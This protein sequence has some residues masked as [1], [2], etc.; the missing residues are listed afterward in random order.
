MSGP[1]RSLLH[2]IRTA[3]RPPVHPRVPMIG[4]VAAVVIPILLH[5]LRAAWGDWV[6]TGDDAYFT[7][8][9][10]DVAT[11]H[12]PLLGAWSSG[13]VDLAEPINNLGPTQ[14]DL[15]APFTKPWPMGGTAVAVAITNAAAVIAIAVMV[16]RLAGRRAVIAAMVPVAL[17]AW[18][19]G[20]EMLITPRQH[21]YLILPYLCVLVATWAIAVGDRWAVPIGVVAASLTTQ[22]HLSYPVLVAVLGV[23]ALVGHVDAMRRGSTLGGRR[24]LVVASLLVLALWAQ[25][26]VDQFAGWGNLGAVLFGSG[27]TDRPG[28]VAGARM[29]AGLLVGP[30]TLFRPGYQRDDT[31]VLL[32]EVWQL[33]VF[34]VAVAAACAGAVVLFR[35]RRRRAAF[36]ITVA[37]A[38]LGAGVVNAALLPRTVFGLAIMNYRWMWATGA[39]VGLVA[40]VIATMWLERNPPRRRAATRIAGAACVLLAV[41]NLP[42]SVQH[43][44]AERYLAEQ[45]AVASVLDQLADAPLRGPVLVDESG[46]YFGH[47]YT[48]PVLVALQERDI[49]FRFESPLQERR[50]G[51]RRVADGTEVTR[52]VMLSGDEATRAADDPRTVAFVPGPRPVA[53]MLTDV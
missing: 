46:M 16:A 11:V 33:A 53:M 4:A 3:L 48:Y 20:S 13:S 14:L 21:Q 22:T 25:T 38:A 52:L 31:D 7:V 15:M 1:M 24:P 28:V 5:G 26:I 18:T 19:M 50:F 43:R 10:R 35:R 45:R 9:S 6:P 36:G 51:S 44:D 27:G 8:R 42:A 32:A 39:F 34:A 29:V 23:V 2:Q 47:P 49:A 37:V 30:V 40:V 41:A 17:L 12:H